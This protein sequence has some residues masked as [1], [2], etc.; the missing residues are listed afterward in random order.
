M[1]F[2]L[3]SLPCGNW[4]LAASLLQHKE[5]PLLH[6]V[7]HL[8]LLSYRSWFPGRYLLS[9]RNKHQR[10]LKLTESDSCFILS[11]KMFPPCFPSLRFICQIHFQRWPEA[12]AFLLLSLLPF[13]VHPCI[14]SSAS[15]AL[16]DFWNS[17]TQ[18]EGEC[19]LAVMLLPCSSAPVGQD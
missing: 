5:T 18:R 6:A 2:Y 15:T 8:S 3:S 7:L 10:S 14:T 9:N 11:C 17:E 4:S 12:R 16:C 13:T 19:A 1:C